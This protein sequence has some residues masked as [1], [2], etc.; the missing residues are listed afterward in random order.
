MKEQWTHVWGIMTSTKDLFSRIWSISLMSRRTAC[1]NHSKP[2]QVSRGLNQK[3]AVSAS[4]R[5][6][7]TCS[8]GWQHGSYGEQLEFLASCATEQLSLEGRGSAVDAAPSSCYTPICS[9]QYHL[10][11]VTIVLIEWVEAK[12]PT[13][14]KSLKILQTTF[15]YVLLIR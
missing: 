11:S 4:R 5:R 3:L 6:S 14:I 1:L 10:W 13:Y 8:M 9:T 2:F 12:A 7:C 15:I